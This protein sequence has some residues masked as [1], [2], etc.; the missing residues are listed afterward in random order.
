[1]SCTLDL[2]SEQ[3][4]ELALRLVATA[5]AVIE[6][7]RP[8]TIDR[9]KLGFDR[10]CE[11]QSRIVMVSLSGYGAGGEWSQYPAYGP[12]MDAVAG[13]AWATRD[14]SGNP[15]SVNGWFPDV[16]GA[17][18]GAIALI[19]AVRRARHTG[20]PMHLE[21]AEMHTLLS[22]LPELL[23]R[24]GLHESAGVVANRSPSGETVML[25]SAGD[26]TWVAF[27]TSAERRGRDFRRAHE[28]LAELVEDPADRVALREPR[29]SGAE[30]SAN[31]LD[32][33]RARVR[34][35]DARAV[36]ECLQSEGINAVP[37]LSAKDLVEDPHLAARESLRREVGHDPET[38]SYAAAW[39]VDGQRQGAQ[40]T[41]APDLGGDNEW[42]LGELLRLSEEE[43]A[44]LTADGVLQ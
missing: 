5:D 41:R 28:A 23:M 21:I 1:L 30:S 4:R 26:D 20:V 25:Q 33:L 15:Q 37:V 31:G 7:F 12:M 32:A 36:T 16:S 42:I 29:N 35:L 44:A 43:I 22:L 3:G 27:G 10:L 40:R 14:Q 17:L 9:M 34:R 13:L 19:D 38:T 24:A 11:V 39:M 8:G 2:K 18:Y 6:N